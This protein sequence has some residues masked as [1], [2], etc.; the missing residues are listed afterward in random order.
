MIFAVNWLELL[1]YEPPPI[2]EEQ[3]NKGSKKSP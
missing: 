1:Q 3:E 2:V